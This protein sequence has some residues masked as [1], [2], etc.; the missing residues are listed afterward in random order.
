[1]GSF[2]GG[3]L[4]PHPPVLLPEVG[5][6]D[7]RRTITTYEAAKRATALLLARSVDTLLVMTPHA[8]RFQD[9]I[10]LFDYPYYAGSLADFRVPQVAC[11][12]PC[13][14][15]LAE[16]LLQAAAPAG[17]AVERMTPETA[18]RFR[19]QTTLD[20]GALVP[21]SFLLQA[22]FAGKLL[23]L[24]PADYPC[25]YFSAFGRLV[26][27]VIDEGNGRVAILASGDLS[28][29]V[30]AESPYGSRPE[31]AQF[32]TAVCQAIQANSFSQLVRDAALIAEP[33]GECGLRSLCFLFGAARDMKTELL[34][35]EAP[36]GIG[37]AVAAWLPE[38]EEAGR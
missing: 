27:S 21:L 12:L 28:H 3:L 1:M 31:G 34:S 20:H 8:P 17:F 37:Y 33:A 23:L 10:A 2:C 4:L 24:S 11:D 38:E 16:A 5:K 26:R 14:R 36:F 25:E 32:D 15:D 29:H 18:V 22:G 13:D 6:A 30:N 35:Y 7:S 9:A 19:C